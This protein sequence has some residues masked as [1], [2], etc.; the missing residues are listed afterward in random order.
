MIS[1]SI[2]QTETRF[3]PATTSIGPSPTDNAKVKMKL[4][5]FVFFNLAMVTA[6]EE[7]TTCPNARPTPENTDCHESPAD[8]ALVIDS[9]SSIG[10]EDN[11]NLGLAFIRDFLDRFEIS[12]D[13][14][15]VAAVMFGQGVYTESAIPFDKYENKQ[16]TLNAISSL[17][18]AG[19][20]ETRTADGIDYMV[21]NFLPKMR[22]DKDVAHVGIVLTDGQSQESNKTLEA[23]KN[24][25]E[26]G[27]TM[28]AVGVG[29]PQNYTNERGN[30]I[31]DIGEL[32]GIAGKSGFVLE[33]G[34]YSKLKSITDLLTSKM[35]II[36]QLKSDTKG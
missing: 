8:I 17:K 27:I 21:Q 1:S 2:I 16:D 14:T 20:Q 4:L 25:R 6:C 3:Q 31:F 15:R 24:A 28:I 10:S 9:T 22:L 12:K 7:T 36:A 23:A 35:C 26:K 33:A 13:K 30:G 19:G 34:N 29:R 18:W 5:I 32:R 11:F